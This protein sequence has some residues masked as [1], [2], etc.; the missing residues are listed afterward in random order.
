MLFKRFFNL[1]VVLQKTYI[2][3]HTA[4]A[5]CYGR[6]TVQNAA[7]D[8]AGIGLTADIK[9]AVKAKVIRDHAVHAVDFVGISAKQLDKACL[10]T[11]GAAAAKKF[12]V[13][14]HKVKLLQIGQKIL[15][16]ECGTLAH[17]DRLRRL[18]VGI[19]QCRG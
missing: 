5:L 7:V 8:L 16:P 18:I 17:R 19:T 12:E 14:Q 13:L 3:C 10:G 15:H 1:A 11:G 2:V 6:K 9:Q 4:A